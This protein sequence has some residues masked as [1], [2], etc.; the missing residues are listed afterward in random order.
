MSDGLKGVRKADY[1]SIYYVAEKSKGYLG[2]ESGK[3]KVIEGLG[4]LYLPRIEKLHRIRRL[5]LIEGTSDLELLKIWAATLGLGWPDDLVE[6]FSTGKPSERKT[7]YGELNK[8]IMKKQNSATLTIVRGIHALS[9]RDRDEEPQA[10][11]RS[12]LSDGSNP[13]VPMQAGEDFRIVHRKWR[14]RH[15]ENYLLLPR[16]IARAASAKGTVYSEEDVA[17]F[18]REEHSATI[19][20]TFVLTD[21]SQAIKDF[22]AKDITYSA[23]NNTETKFDVTRF[24][25]ARSMTPAEICDDVKG[26]LN[27]IVA[28]CTPRA[29]TSP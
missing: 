2:E 18:L 13:D 5:L 14:R 24:D 1:R 6:W 25:I 20:D 17:R 12:D 21:C 27:Q 3:V 19:N 11:T 26:L 22:R 23:P 8:E 29:G 16:A 4:S 7:L 28:L 9:L 10:T 15:I